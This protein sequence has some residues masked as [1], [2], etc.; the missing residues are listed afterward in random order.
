MTLLVVGLGN[1]GTRYA[2]TRHNAGFRVAEAFAERIHVPA[3]RDKF[4]GEFTRTTVD[5]V[6]LL[7]LRPLTFMNE[8]GRSVRAA[9]SFFRIPPSETLVI[10][11]ELDLSFGELRLK[12]GGGHAG[13]NGL[14]SIFEAIATDQFARL[15]VG[16][17]RPPRGWTGDVADF[18]LSELNA[19]ERAELDAAVQKA[20]DAVLMVAQKGLTAATNALNARPKKNKEPG[21]SPPPAQQGGG[22][23]PGN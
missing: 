11:D 1:P 18:V 20:A 19:I 7:L 15:R 16:I 6:E 17:G 13:H 3:W 4:H 8:S 14:R 23:E 9:M 22:A 21:S 5:G 2:R 12:F 10:H